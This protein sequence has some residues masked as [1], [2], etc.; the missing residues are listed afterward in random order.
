[1]SAEQSARELKN[2]NPNCGPLWG[3]IAKVRPKPQHPSYYEWQHGLLVLVLR[4][5]NPEH[6]AETARTIVEELPYELITDQFAVHSPMDFSAACGVA[7]KQG[8]ELGL[9]LVL[10]VVPTGA[11]E[12]EFEAMELP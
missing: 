9:G 6:A 11:D 8:R 5:P 3:V 2:D 12:E 4:A 7:V 10:H 1:M